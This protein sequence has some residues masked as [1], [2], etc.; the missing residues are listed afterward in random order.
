MYCTVLVNRSEWIIVFDTRKKEFTTIKCKWFSLTRSAM[1]LMKKYCNHCIE[2]SSIHKQVF[3]VH[4]IE[5]T[6]TNLLNLLK[7]LTLNVIYSLHFP[8]IQ[9]MLFTPQH[10]QSFFRFVYSF[11]L[12]LRCVCRLSPI[13]KQ[14]LFNGYF[15]F[16]KTV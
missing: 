15:I 2:N 10:S 4:Y 13:Q 9:Y 6:F 11:V 16:W 14:K 8:D 1:K 5:L 12:V 7:S 3:S